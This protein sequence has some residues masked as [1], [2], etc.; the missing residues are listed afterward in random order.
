[1]ALQEDTLTIWLNN[2]GKVPLLPES[3]IVNLSKRIHKH[4]AESKIGIRAVNK[5]V[6]HNLRLVP[7]VTRKVIAV[8][9]DF[10]FGD[11]NTVDLLQAGTFGLHR[12]AQK[13]DYSRGYKFS[14]YAYMW[15]RQT[16]QRQMYSLSSLLHV[17]E[18]YFREQNILDDSEAVKEMMEKQP[19]KY[20]CTVCARLALSPHLGIEFET[21]DGHRELRS[22]PSLITQ[23]LE[24]RED[25]DSIF[26]L[27]P[28]LIDDTHKNIVIDVCCN[29]MSLND[30][31]KEYSISRHAAS[32]IVKKTLSTLRAAY[33]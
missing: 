26:S 1:M 27:A 19:R 6:R 11:P 15:I 22:D 23:S 10:K 32:S 31:S 28:Q 5:I 2:A 30:I 20:E 29:D 13:F 33:S 21:E 9:K 24:A 4:G 8:R 25:I 17:P 12:A 3:E 14:T 18:S 7:L 16:V